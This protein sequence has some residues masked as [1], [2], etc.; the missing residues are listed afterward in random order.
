MGGWLLCTGRQLSI[1]KLHICEILV[2]L[3]VRACVHVC[4]A[5]HKPRIH[6]RA[7]LI[8]LTDSVGGLQGVRVLCMHE[9][10]PVYTHS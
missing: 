6:P 1:C 5:R 2:S 9:E 10:P 4:A 8:M 7:P 3:C